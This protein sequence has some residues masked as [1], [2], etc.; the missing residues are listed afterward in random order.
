MDQQNHIDSLLQRLVD[1]TLTKTEF[2]ELMAIID[3][4]DSSVAVNGKLQ[5]LWGRLKNMRQV[6]N[7]RTAYDPDIVFHKIWDKIERIENKR[8]TR[9]SILSRNGTKWMG[10]AATLLLIAGFLFIYQK[11]N[12]TVPSGTVPFANTGNTEVITLQLDNG[13]IE[14]ISENG[15]RVITTQ[16]GAV[17]GSQQGASLNYVGNEVNNTLVYNT[18]NIPHGKRF[19]LVLSDGTKVKLNSGSSLRY[20][21]QFL[22]GNNRDVFLMG[23]AYFEVAKDT[24]HPFIVNVDD[25]KVQVLGT[26]FNLSYY[27]E[28]REITTVLVEGSVEL[29]KDGA[30]KN[31]HTTTL[32]RP[33]Q[34][35]AWRSA[36][37]EMSVQHVDT[38]IYTAWKEGYL[39]FKAA[40]FSII[41]TRLQRHFNITIEDEGKH[42]EDQVYTATFREETI[43]EI[44]EAFKEDT[45]FIYTREDSKIII[46]NSIN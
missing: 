22:P 20:P 5:D 30:N 33:G 24:E 4:L 9:K 31:T 2:D 29:F 7:D 26:Q 40:P 19:D 6:N 28:D 23:E 32:L 36:K 43:E 15:E 11:N 3:D 42:M 1:N 17:I 8:Q 46:T 13:T 18:L 27:P 21:V 39:L 10:I 35:A 16:Q 38:E 25:L 37:N 14:T 41:K 12:T 44:L 45:P 34:K